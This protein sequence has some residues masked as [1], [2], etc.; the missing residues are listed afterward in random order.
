MILRQV[1]LFLLAICLWVPTAAFA[2]SRPRLEPPRLT[3]RPMLPRADSLVLPSVQ[4]L[5][6]TCVVPTLAGLYRREYGVSYAYGTAVA[7]SAGL[8][9]A[10]LREA[11]LPWCT[12]G[13]V[14]AWA[15]ILYGARL[16]LFLLYREV[17][18][19][20]FRK[21]RDR[22][23]DRAPVGSRLLRLP[24][25]L[26]CS[27]L[28]GCLATPLWATASVI[29]PF[30]STTGGIQANL[31]RLAVAGTWWGFVL[32][33]VGDVTKSWVKAREG[34][35]QLVTGGVFRWFRHPNYTGEVI[36]WISSALAA[37]SVGSS[38]PVLV[39]TCLGVAGIYSVL[40]MATA[41][42]EKK[43]AE[44]YGELDEYQ[45]WIRRSWVGF[46]K[47]GKAK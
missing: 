14:H 47:A 43:Q 37:A 13:S 16:D 7:A 11:A 44:A 20:R 4:T 26:S 15:L 18:L 5:A 12:I 27:A 39:A 23:E 28:Y 2:P 33:A 45:E 3:P 36:G 25:I 34:E 22:I 10:A 9:L 24:F 1:K 30:W 35:E 29:L 41:N 40:T 17:C 21:L 38:W 32:A 31:A 42:L 6:T 46:T 8:M 19:E